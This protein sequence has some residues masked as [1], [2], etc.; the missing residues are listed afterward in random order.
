MLS[1]KFQVSWPFDSGEEAKN[2]FSRWP[3]WLPSWIF[4]RNDFSHFLSTSHLKASNQVLSPLAQRCRRSRL[5]KQ[6]LTLQDEWQTMHYGY[7][8]I[9]T[10]HRAENKQITTATAYLK[11]QMFYIIPQELLG[12]SLNSYPA[13]KISDLGYSHLSTHYFPCFASIYFTLTYV[14][15]QWLANFKWN[16]SD[17][18]MNMWWWVMFASHTNMYL[19]K[20]KNPKV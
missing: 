12:T 6:L 15:Y 19:K 17:H 2:R 7:W 1:T 14:I 11:M 9:T 20:K 3:P 8:L 10:A 18:L 13:T 16:S 4:D 5:L